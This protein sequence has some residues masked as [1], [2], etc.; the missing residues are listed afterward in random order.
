MVIY[1]NDNTLACPVVNDLVF[2]VIYNTRMMNE[3]ADKVVN[4]LVF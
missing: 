1:N 2:E 4:D 3:M